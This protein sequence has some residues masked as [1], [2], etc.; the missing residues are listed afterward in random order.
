MNQHQFT[1]EEQA[2]IDQQGWN[3]DSIRTILDAH[4]GYGGDR[5]SYM[6][7]VAA[8]ENDVQLWGSVDP[9]S[10]SDLQQTSAF[11]VEIDGEYGTNDGAIRLMNREQEIVMWDSAEWIE[12]PSLVYVIVNAIRKGFAEG[13]RAVA[14]TIGV[15]LRMDCTE[16]GER[17]ILNADETTNHLLDE[18]AYGIDH[19][20]DADHVALL[21]EEYR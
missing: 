9:A 8:I 19:D 14:D 2:I 13:P 17:M 20:A 21:P 16:C 5:L 1:P 4:A 10:T 7:G 12:D 3:E 11:T 6:K 18:D 15:L